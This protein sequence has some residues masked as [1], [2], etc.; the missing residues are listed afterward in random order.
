MRILVKALIV[1]PGI[2][3]G[4]V[5]SV[6]DTIVKSAIL[7]LRDSTQSSPLKI[8]SVSRR[9]SRPNKLPSRWT[10]D[11]GFMVQSPHSLKRRMSLA[12]PRKIPLLTSF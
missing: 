10:K 9:S 12:T 5:E 3:S 6:H 1:L 7:I 11:A 4:T 2:P 8:A